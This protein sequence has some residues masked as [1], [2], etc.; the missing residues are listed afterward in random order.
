MV[1]HA[2]STRIWPIVESS[3]AFLS[4]CPPCGR[5][6]S[7]LDMEEDSSRYAQ[8]RRTTRSR[9]GPSQ[10]VI[11]CGAPART[12]RSIW[13]EPALSCRNRLSVRHL[14][15]YRVPSD[16]RRPTRSA[17]D[18]RHVVA[19]SYTLSRDTTT[20]YKLRSIERPR[21]SRTHAPMIDR[22]RM[23]RV[24]TT[25]ALCHC[26]R[27]LCGLLACLCSQIRETKGL[28]QLGRTR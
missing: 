16:F 25:H 7:R 26:A 18:Q 6:R 8:R 24:A 14:A 22:S 3:A 5:T 9:G 27:P 13:T 15:Y 19:L 17:S 2:A 23:G 11:P 12:S 1:A 4:G 21:S 28:I 20:C 10:K